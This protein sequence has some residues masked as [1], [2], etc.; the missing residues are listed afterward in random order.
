MAQIKK[1]LT[2]VDHGGITSADFFRVFDIP[3]PRVQHSKKYDREEWDDEDYKY[4]EGRIRCH[5]W[6]T[7]A[8]HSIR[9]I[10]WSEA[11]HRRVATYVSSGVSEGLM[12]AIT[13]VKLQ[14]TISIQRIVRGFLTRTFVKSHIVWYK[15]LY[16][17]SALARTTLV[18]WSRVTKH[19]RKKRVKLKTFHKWKALFR[20]VGGNFDSAGTVPFMGWQGKALRVLGR[21]TFWPLYSWRKAVAI[22]KKRKATC[23][24][25][26]SL[27]N[28]WL[29]LR[30][31]KA[32][33]STWKQNKQYR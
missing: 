16:E 8:D 14:A 22:S 33:N 7:S 23:R 27:F 5:P 6:L 20:K 12:D 25:M 21:S 15:R 30:I 11:A 26:I 9:K 32:W 13:R 29:K 10:G 18:Q 17:Q 1:T 3:R 28:T 19:N 2:G 24:K 4:L 31:F